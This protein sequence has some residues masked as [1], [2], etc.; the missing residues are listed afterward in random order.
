PDRLRLGGVDPAVLH[1]RAG[2][3][4][5]SVR[6]PRPAGGGLMANPQA[7]PPSRFAAGEPHPVPPPP[8]PPRGTPPPAASAAPLAPPVTY[9]GFPF[10][11]AVLSSLKSGRELFRVDYFPFSWEFGNYTAVFRGQ[12]FGTNILNSLI[13]SF[14]VVALSLLLGITAAFALA[15]IQF[16]GRSTLLITILGVSMFPQVDVLS[17][18]FQLIQ[19]LVLYNHIVALNLS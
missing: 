9:A 11:Y 2:D 1:R 4:R 16:R 7:P 6:E 3:P 17:S 18:M 14:A 5:G 19:G 12:P 15:R 8:R 13:V 10:Y